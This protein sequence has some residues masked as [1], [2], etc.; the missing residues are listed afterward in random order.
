MNLQELEAAFRATTYRVA[1]DGRL[2]DLRIDVSAPDF[3]EWLDQQG[4]SSWGIVTAC[5]PGGQ[6]SVAENPARLRAFRQRLAERCHRGWSCHQTIHRADSGRWPDEP[7]VCVLN[8][9]EDALLRLASEF[10]QVAI[11]FGAA[12]GVGRLVWVDGSP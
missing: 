10:G 8:A 3:V 4:A 11:V 5:N 6:L 2:F 9:S 7:G 1:S 12:D